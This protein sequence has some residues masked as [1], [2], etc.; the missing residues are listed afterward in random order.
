MT[1]RSLIV[2]SISLIIPCTGS[3]QVWIS[4]QGDDTYINPIL[5]LDYSD[6]D[7][8]R[9]GSDFYMTASSFN[10]VPGLP[11]LHSKD[12]VNWELINYALPKQY[13]E[14]VFSRPQHF[15]GVWA[16]CIRYH[17]GTY[18]IYYGD[19]DFGIY[20]LTA[21]DPAG[22]WS[23]PKLVVAGKGLIDPSPLW[24]DDGNVYLVHAWAASR[25]RVN[26]LLTLRKLDPT[27]TRAL[28]DGRH[29]FDGHLDHTTVEGP[30]FYKR[31]GYYYIF[32]PA[33][34][35]AT[36]WQLILRSKNI[37]GPY[38]EKVVLEQ[39][40]TEING[41]HQ[42]GWVD[43]PTGQDWFVHFQD[44]EAYGRIVH[45]QPVRWVDD[46]PLMGKDLDGNGVG[47]PVSRHPKPD[48]GQSY[49]IRYL[50]A[51]DDFSG[52]DFGK[53]WQ[54]HANPHVVWSAKLPGTDYLRLFAM[55]RPADFVNHWS[56]P[57]LLLQKFPAPS[58]TATTEL[59]LHP[60]DTGQA[61]GL[62]IMGRDYASLQLERVGGGYALIQQS[63]TDADKGGA[64]REVS[65]VP[66]QEST[67]Q[68]RVRVAAPD[69][70][71]QFQYSTDGTTFRDIGPPFAAR[72][73]GWIGTK[74][75]L[76]STKSTDSGRGGFGEFA[77][78]SVSN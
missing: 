67:V 6:P 66:V 17:Q 5:H 36:G 37:Y 32:A 48:V 27:G 33:G 46:W 44:K 51:S 21:T 54:W 57:H 40:T 34:G 1:F 41:P 2:I 76:Y 74:V 39:G 10:C 50:A 30:K 23:K 29:V 25:V 20:V 8:V 28:D 65:R 22:T 52:S 45:L 7:V 43:T 15:K 64:E 77:W 24:D 75:G 60:T 47:E 68:L 35:V 9:V 56:T 72:P 4:D 58:F 31:N 78:F 16:P 71:C 62:I 19:P 49:P 26:S 18:Y 38:E 13:P 61:A 42:G 14:E 53:Q 63:C 12:L 73:G 11:I 59:T 69:A 3:A 55:P 70:T